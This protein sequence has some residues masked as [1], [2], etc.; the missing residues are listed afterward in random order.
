MIVVDSGVVVDALTGAPGAEQLRDRIRV[1]ELHAPHLLDY[2]VVSV[3]RGLSLGG[4]LSESRVDDAL[5]DFDDLAVMRWS[6]SEPL[7]RR[8]FLMR[9]N[10]TDYD[11]AY[12][13]LAEALECP[14]LTRDARVAKAVGHDARIEVW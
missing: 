1:E 9:H 7:R 6:A 8:A 5:T 10:L 11:A 13:A 4:H 2:E 12:V 3:I 14:L